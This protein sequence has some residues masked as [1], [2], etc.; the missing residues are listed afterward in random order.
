LLDTVQSQYDQASALTRELDR[1][2]ELLQQ[3][4]HKLQRQAE[5]LKAQTGLLQSE[6]A[7]RRKADRAAKK[8][9]AAKPPTTDLNVVKEDEEMS[10]GSSGSQARV[11]AML[12]GPGL[13]GARVSSMQEPSKYGTVVRDGATE[14]QATVVW[15]SAPGSRVREARSAVKV[16]GPSDLGDHIAAAVVV[17]PWDGLWEGP[18]HHPKF[19][20]VEFSGT[21]VKLADGTTEET[22]RSHVCVW[23]LHSAV[24]TPCSD[25][26]FLDLHSGERLILVRPE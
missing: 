9:A 8:K 13:F 26:L 20:A 18:E 24:V 5:Q 6:R 19:S 21:S 15:D 1:R 11:N 7:R 10:Q 22:V 17:P 16:L 25:T 2:N 14:G 23:Y 12:G 4:Q 3:Q